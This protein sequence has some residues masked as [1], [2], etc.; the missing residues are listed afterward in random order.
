MLL[1]LDTEYTG[2]DSPTPTLISLGIVTEDGQR[3]FYVELKDTWKE[4]DCSKFVKREVL[5]VLARKRGLFKA[6][7]RPTAIGLPPLQGR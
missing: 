5:P 1:F 6:G 3:E 2:F 4:A 7:A